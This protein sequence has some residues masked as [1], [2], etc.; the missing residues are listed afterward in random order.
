MKNEISKEVKDEMENR[1]L[2]GEFAS[3]N[4]LEQ[5]GSSLKKFAEYK[6]DVGIYKGVDCDVSLAAIVSYHKAYGYLSNGCIVK[7][8][9]NPNETIII[10]KKYEIRVQ[11][12]NS[13]L[14]IY[15]GDTMTSAITVF[16]KYLYCLWESENGT[17]AFKGLFEKHSLNKL[18]VPK[19]I[20]DEYYDFNDYLFDKIITDAYFAKTIYDE[21]SQSARKFLDNWQKIGNFIPVPPLVNISRCNPGDRK[22]VGYWDTADRMLW[23][24]YQYFHLRDKKGK[25]DKQYLAQMFSKN[26]EEATENTVNWIGDCGGTWESFVE[27]NMLEAFVTKKGLIPK[28]LKC[29]QSSEVEVAI[30]DGNIN[31]DYKNPLP[32]TAEE[33]ECFFANAN[34]WIE[35]RSIAIQEKI[36]PN[37]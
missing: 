18:Q 29:S 21:M 25:Y 5:Y 30:N 28:A 19:L 15:R 4:Y 33:F 11:G 17:S 36:N 9:S 12:K 34:A 13:S 2:V 7:Q 10:P 26:K 22:R 8:T 37:R 14:H 31:E 20:E 35:L 6:S 3:Q 1:L 24:I 23:K 27:Q 16:K 32:E